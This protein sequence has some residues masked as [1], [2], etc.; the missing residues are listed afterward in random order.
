[1]NKDQVEKKAEEAKGKGKDNAVTFLR[2]KKIK[3]KDNA[4]MNIGKV[5]LGFDD[6]KENEGKN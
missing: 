5:K 1:M 6:A 4:E 3:T 2:D